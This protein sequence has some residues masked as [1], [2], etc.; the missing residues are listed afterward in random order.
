MSTQMKQRT[1]FLVAIVL[2]MLSQLSFSQETEK[3]LDRSSDPDDVVS[4]FFKSHTKEVDKLFLSEDWNEGEILFSDGTLVKEYPI[5]YDLRGEKIE[6]RFD[7]DVLVQSIKKISWFKMMNNKTGK[8]EMFT[9]AAGIMNEDDI[10]LEGI[11][12]QDA[13]GEVSYITNFFFTVKEPDYNPRAMGSG[14]TEPSYYVRHKPYLCKDG[15]VYQKPASKKTLSKVFGSESN[16]A[17]SYVKEEKLNP[18]KEE[19]MEVLLNYMNG[20]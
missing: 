16:K 2:L 12:R 7:S 18:K 3:V 8:M 9:N 20:L 13:Q 14:S 17:I 11:C 10:P 15:V 5:R 4:L 19:D 1:T 6:A